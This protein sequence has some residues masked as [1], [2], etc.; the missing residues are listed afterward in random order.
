MEFESL[1]RT[2]NVKHNHRFLYPLNLTFSNSS[3][4]ILMSD[5]LKVKHSLIN[6]NFFYSK[7]NNNFITSK[8][9]DLELGL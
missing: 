2:Q 3:S 4:T 9:F 1:F 5:Y 7:P 8:I 6:S